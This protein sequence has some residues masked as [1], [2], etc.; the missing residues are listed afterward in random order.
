MSRYRL[1]DLD[2]SGFIPATRFRRNRAVGG[3][4]PVLRLQPRN[5]DGGAIVSWPEH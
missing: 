3:I 5:E 2:L 1:V 4:D